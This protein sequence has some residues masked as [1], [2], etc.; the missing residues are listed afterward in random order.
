M[1]TLSK[2]RIKKRIHAMIERVFGSSLTEFAYV[3]YK[4]IMFY[5]GIELLQDEQKLFNEAS[6]YIRP[7]DTVLDIGAYLGVWAR[8]LSSVVGSS[9]R[10]IAFEPFP[11]NLD[12][13]KKLCKKYQNIDVCD[14]ALSDKNCSLEMIFPNSVRLPSISAMECSADQ[15]GD[16]LKSKFRNIDVNAYCLDDVICD[17]SIQKISF[18]KIDVEGHE[19]QVVRGAKKTLVENKPFITLE[20]LEEKWRGGNPL[21][22]EVGQFLIGLG[23]EMGQ[24][25]DNNIVYSKTFSRRSE[26]FVFCPEHLKI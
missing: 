22:S 1:S 16:E 4:H 3:Y 19:L 2:Q 7:G 21:L 5:L 13:L 15:F 9:G 11:A 20:I 24:L 14:F 18:V 26:N 25:I 23:Y 8:K 12:L 17:L 10:V 6:C